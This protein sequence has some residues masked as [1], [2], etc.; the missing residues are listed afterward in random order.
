MNRDGFRAGRQ[1]AEHEAAHAV[2]AALTG[3]VVHRASIAPSR[4]QRPQAHGLMEYFTDDLPAALQKTGSIDVSAAGLA[5]ELLTTRKRACD[6]DLALT[7]WR[8]RHRAWASARGDRQKHSLLPFLAA[9]ARVQRT[10][11]RPE[12]A[13]AVQAVADAIQSRTSGE[14]HGVT[15]EKIVLLHVPNLVRQQDTDGQWVRGL[16]P[17]TTAPGTGLKSAAGLSADGAR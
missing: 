17:A 3:R 7:R 12:V 2:I 9:V 4:A 8:L 11:K 5:W 14:I 6:Q 13:A 10:L 1:V 15:V 16:V